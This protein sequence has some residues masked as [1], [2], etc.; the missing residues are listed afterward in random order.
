M[1]VVG[2]KSRPVYKGLVI[3]IH[4]ARH[5]FA[6]EGEGAEALLDQIKSGQRLSQESGSRRRKIRRASCVI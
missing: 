5:L 6:L 3:D 4:S 2:I 1:L